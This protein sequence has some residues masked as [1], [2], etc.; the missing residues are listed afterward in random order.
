MSN[1]TPTWPRKPVYVL[2]KIDSTETTW[3]NLVM[4]K[5]FLVVTGIQQVLADPTAAAALG[6][7]MGFD[8]SK[9]PAGVDVFSMLGKLPPAVL[10]QI[11]TT[12]NAKF[13][14]LGDSMIIQS[15]TA[16]VKAEYT[17]LGMG[18]REAVDELYYQ[19]RHPDA[20]GDPA[21]RHLYHHCGLSWR[22]V[23]QPGLARD[24]R[25]YVFQ[26]VE[27]FSSTEFDK[28]STASL[29]TR[30]TNDVTRSRWSSS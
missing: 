29:I 20:A 19:H 15:A 2:N 1:S 24:L 12:F 8:L 23:V 13:S 7:S 16:P 21:L 18:H 17:A 3:L 25:R 5:S 30:S 9:L 22:L 26:R 27:S 28:F 10:S 6:K 4:A 14:A 11:S